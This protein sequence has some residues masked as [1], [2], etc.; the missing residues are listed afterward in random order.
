MIE[1]VLNHPLRR[2]LVP[3]QNQ[4]HAQRGTPIFGG[5]AGGRTGLIRVLQ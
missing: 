3:R 4:F 2:N 1:L 5:A